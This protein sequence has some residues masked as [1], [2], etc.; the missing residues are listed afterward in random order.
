M[1]IV[2]DGEESEAVTVD[3]GVPQGKVLGPLL[4]L[5]HINDL[6]DT[7]KSTVRLFFLQMTAFYI[8]KSNLGKIIFYFNR[9]GQ[10]HGECV[11]MPRIA[12]SRALT[13]NPRVST[14]WI[15]TFYNR[16]QKIHIK[17]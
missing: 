12:T 1:R 13:P 7:V 16:F 17:V 3:S 6:P 10:R 5:C 4:F 2:I 11:S 9:H 8:D 15:A 14:D